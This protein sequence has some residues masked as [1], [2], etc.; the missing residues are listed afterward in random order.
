MSQR[1][2]K[3]GLTGTI[4]AAIC[5]FTPVLVWLMAALGLSAH[6]GKLDSFL[7]PLLGVFAAFTLISYIKGRTA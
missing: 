6:L 7:L 2:F 3:I 5:C 1:W 4:V